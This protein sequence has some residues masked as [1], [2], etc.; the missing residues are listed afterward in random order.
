[1]IEI[2]I[3]MHPHDGDMAGQL[4]THME[5]LGFK[6]ATLL[7]T[8]A[9]APQPT[10]ETPKVEVEKPAARPSGRTRAKNAEKAA[11]STGEERT[12]PEDTPETQQQDAADEAAEVAETKTEVAATLDDVRAAAGAYLKKFG[13]DAAQ[14]DGAKVLTMVCGEGVVKMSDIPADKI[15]AVV[16]GF[17]EMTEKNPFQREQVK[18]A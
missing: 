6:R 16:A 4:N 3:E 14:Q 8:T 11:I 13:M 18:A 7:S 17:A 15:K 1:M 2:K 5:A 9:P 10:V 12:G